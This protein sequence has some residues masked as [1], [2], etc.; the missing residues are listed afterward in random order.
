MYKQILVATDGSKLGDKA[1]K[2]A[3]GLAKDSGARVTALYAAP[4]YKTPYYPE[5]VYYDWP[6]PADYKKTV[7]QTADKFLNKVTKLA[8]DASVKAEVACVF[9]DHPHQAI[10]NQAK[11][12][13]ADV[14]V[15]ASHGRRAVSS[16]LL[17]SETQKVLSLTKIPVLVIR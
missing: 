13:K 12:V 6:Q 9:N 2:A 15:M 16:L 14:I 17:G 7:S 1:V 4:E 8:A 10:I 5:G 11:K 3:I